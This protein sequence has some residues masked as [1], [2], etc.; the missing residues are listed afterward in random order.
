MVIASNTEKG[1]DGMRVPSQRPPDA[2]AAPEGATAVPR[3][4]NR[5]QGTAGHDPAKCA[6]C[7]GYQPW[8]E[9]RRD[10]ARSDAAI[11]GR[12]LDEAFC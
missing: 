8:D 3:D 6:V 5:L 10:E 1:P 7:L 9:T 11:A 2:P 12:Q 4:E